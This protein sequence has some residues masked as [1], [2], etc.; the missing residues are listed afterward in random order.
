M[1]RVTRGTWASFGRGDQ[2]VNFDLEDPMDRTE[3]DAH[4]AAIVDPARAEEIAMY[5]GVG[6]LTD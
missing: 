1:D 4:I 2:R 6:K 5:V 3:M